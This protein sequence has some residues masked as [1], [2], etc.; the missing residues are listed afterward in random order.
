M[1]WLTPTLLYFQTNLPESGGVVEV[2]AERWAERPGDC[3][4]FGQRLEP[5]EPAGVYLRE[6][7][8]AGGKMSV[9]EWGKHEPWLMK[10]ARR[11]VQAENPA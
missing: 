8:F 5:D 4:G 6:V 1:E 2:I 10:E 11:Y 7:F 3:D 9:L